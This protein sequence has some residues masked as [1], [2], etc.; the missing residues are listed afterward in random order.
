MER[1]SLS[2]RIAYITLIDCEGGSASGSWPLLGRRFGIYQA[3]TTRNGGE[4]I[5]ANAY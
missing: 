2:A 5:D 4:V 1:A 3:L